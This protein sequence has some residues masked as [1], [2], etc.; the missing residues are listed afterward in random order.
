MRKNVYGI[1]NFTSYFDRKVMRLSS[2]EEYVSHRDY[3]FTEQTNFAMNDGVLSSAVFNLSSEEQESIESGGIPNYVIVCDAERKIL[4]R[5]YVTEGKYIRENQYEL[6]LRRDVVADYMDELLSA[7][8]M[9]E[10]APLTPSSPYLYNR[11]DM[12]FN[13]IKVSETLIQDE[14]RRAWIVGYVSDDTTDTSTVTADTDQSQ[15]S[16]YPTLAQA[17]PGIEWEDPSDPSKGGTFEGCHQ[18]VDYVTSARL[19][20][21]NAGIST[22]YKSFYLHSLGSGS[23][24]VQEIFGWDAGFNHE[25]IRHGLPNYTDVWGDA[26]SDCLKWI[27]KVEGA[28]SVL[29][30]AFATKHSV[31]TPQDYAQVL[32]ANGRVF[33]DSVNQ[34]Y[35]R[36][37]VTQTSTRTL[38]DPCPADSLPD[39]RTRLIALS[40]A[41]ASEIGEYA[42]YNENGYVQAKAELATLTVAA[43]EVSVEGQLK[44]TMVVGHRKLTDAPYDMFC[45]EFNEGNLALAQRIVTAPPGAGQVKKIYD[46]QILPFC[47]RRD[48]VPSV[49]GGALDDSGLTEGVDYQKIYETSGGSDVEVGRLYWCV[50]SSFSFFSDLPSPIEIDL[51]G[52]ASV[53]KKVSDLCD[54]YRLSSPNYS[55]SFDFSLAKNGGYLSSF[56]IDFT[57][58]PV[59]PYIHVAPVFSGLYGSFNNDARGLICGGDFSVDM[60]S[61]PWTEYMSNN[62]NYE[63]IFNTQIKKLDAFR[64]YDRGALALSGIMA[65]AGATAAGALKGGVAGAAVGFAAGAAR[66]IGQAVVSEGKYQAERKAMIDTFSYELGNVRAAPNSLTKV[67]AYNVNNKYFPVLEKYTATDEEKEAARRYF[68][69]YNFKVG[70]VGTL[71][72]FLDE[73]A[74]KPWTFV[75]GKV[76]LLPEWAKSED[77]HFIS[78]A[79]AEIER[80]VFIYGW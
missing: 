15:T 7:D 46:L 8:C 10:R 75:S 30:S 62:K 47:P 66:S 45:L 57:Y 60:I 54:L 36:L 43:Q 56:K 44:T 22:D 69:L 65:T 72:S 12:A 40:G 11:E 24:N 18:P 61:D 35:Y 3:W 25:A 4:S 39:L 21:R 63:N 42:T 20:N 17:L 78:E 32:S 34:K 50:K 80:G 13:Q 55:A 58:R 1:K 2:F 71:R 67:S 73:G 31:G 5:W 33:Y 29:D 9:V 38:L 6:T 37:T 41:V 16:S 59:M 70:V 52:D 14:T 27:S 76:S 26:S 53:E 79:Y 28:R 49:P 23:G 74:G 68:R 64:E 77:S 51:A 48:I 19:Y